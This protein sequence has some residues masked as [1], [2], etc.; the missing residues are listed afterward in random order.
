MHL[1]LPL[2]MLFGFLTM[3]VSHGAEYGPILAAVLFAFS[4]WSLIPVCAVRTKQTSRVGAVLVFAAGVSFAVFAQGRVVIYP[5]LGPDVFGVPL[6]LFVLWMGLVLGV[7]AAVMRVTRSW[8]LGLAIVAGLVCAWSLVLNPAGFLLGIF[9]Y[10]TPGMYYGIP[11]L[12]IVFWI[13]STVLGV[14]GVWWVS[15][16]REAVIP[17]A[18]MSGVLCTLAF[19]T[20]VCVAEGAWVPAVLGLVLTQA[21]FWAVHHL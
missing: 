20:G 13:V 2:L 7:A 4:I 9:A 11:F 17:L 21:G 14:A 12:H 1:L 3:R 8:F 10:Y 5:R 15:G 18:S 6:V 19:A 16:R